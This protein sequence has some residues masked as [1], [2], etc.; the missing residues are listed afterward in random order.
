MVSTVAPV[1]RLSVEDV[2]TMVR[3]GVLDEDDRVELVEGVLVEMSPIGPSHDGTV[4]WLMFWFVK[5]AEAFSVR[6]QSMFLTV[7][8]GYVLPDLTV[9]EPLAD[10]RA[11]QPRTA[12]LVVEVAQSS[13][14]RDREKVADYAAAGV[15]EY[16]IADLDLGAVLVHRRP[17]GEAYAEVSEHHDG[18]L[19][20]PVAAP[21]IPVAELLG[22]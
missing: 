10:P 16:W 5:A 20:P 19:E 12:L 18:Y 14:A 6:V 11:E 22:R 3:A 21:P 8:G 15:R 4:E 7:E 9:L 13:G 1:R 17:E 2:L